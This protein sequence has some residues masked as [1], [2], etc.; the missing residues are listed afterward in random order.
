MLEQSVSKLENI[1]A[2]ST[3]TCPKC[4]QSIPADDINVEKDIAFCRACNLMHK[5]SAL[6]QVNDLQSGV[7]LNDPPPGAWRRQE[8]VETVVGATHRALGMALAALVFCLFWNGIVSLFVLHNAAATFRLLHIPA[9]AWFPAAKMNGGPMGV[10]MTIFLWIFLT[11]FM[12]IGLGMFWSFLSSLGGRTEVRITGAQGVVFTG[13][14]PVGWRRRFEPATITD[15]RI[16]DRSW[17][18]RNGNPRSNSFIVL[19]T[20]EGK[21]IKFGTSLSNERR[22]FVAA[23]VRRAV[24]R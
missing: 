6:V 22:K 5:L 1:S 10:G 17:N 7:D 9:P 21:Q 8:G 16:E 23:A 15:V 12:A 19:E 14:G 11:P 18:D 13:I 24:I 2:M 20:R 3:P 4:G